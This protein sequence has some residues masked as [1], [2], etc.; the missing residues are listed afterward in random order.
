[1]P[2]WVPDPVPPGDADGPPR[3]GLDGPEPASPGSPAQF[4]PDS[5]GTSPVDPDRPGFQPPPARLPEAVPLAPP[6]RFGPA[7]TRLGSFAGNGSSQDMRHGLRH[8]VRKGYGGA[9]SASRRMGGTARSAG[10]LY[11][12]LV[13]AAAGGPGTP[14]SPF[15]PVLL[16]GRSVDD[17][18]DALVE[19]VR[20]IDGTQDAD[21]SRGAIRN[22][23]SE[24]L[25]R[26]PEADLLNLTDD[27]RLFGIEGFVA[28]DIYNRF[29]LDVGKTIHDKAPTA[30]AALSRLKDVKDYVKQ[31]VSACFRARV[32]TGETLGARRI[33]DLV[34]QTLRATFKVF[35]DY[36]R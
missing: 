17:V 1:M 26:F 15:D 12:A 24:L 34:R 11:G 32:K 20:P 35:E 33:T 9:R 7:R 10:I 31:T 4:V 3:A 14:G 16:S 22:A 23:M 29:V 27:Q 2:P 13:G 18:M 30:I 5:D 25:D 19:A 36:V 8:Y 28:L 6:G 21:A